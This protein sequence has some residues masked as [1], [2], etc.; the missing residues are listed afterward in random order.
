M[1]DLVLLAYESA[2][3][4]MP[5]IDIDEFRR[6]C[7]GWLFLPIDVKGQ[8]VAVLMTNGP[9][10]HVCIPDQAK[11]RWSARA[12]W[13]QYIAPIVRT[14]GYVQTEVARGNQTG[15]DFVERMG[16]TPFAVTDEAII[17]RKES[18]DYG[19]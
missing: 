4:R 1:I 11:R 6:V 10:V 17:Y 12:V 13:R 15:R 5:G 9:R 2:K 19:R 14:Y 16:F 3:D 8:T 18:A 7:A